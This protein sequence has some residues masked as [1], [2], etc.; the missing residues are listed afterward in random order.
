[1]LGFSQKETIN[2]EMI[3]L[4]EGETITINNTKIKF[5][6]VLEDSRCPK[7][8]SC[9]WEGRAKVLIKIEPENGQGYTKE[10][11]FGALRGNE[12][13][14]T[15]FIQEDEYF[16]EAISLKPYPEVDAKKD[17][18]VLWICEGS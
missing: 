13:A 5:L 12:K 18:Y 14:N 9:I 6:K 1:M 8:A 17:N 3:S 7:N 11:I 15:T 4:I 16:V 10:I 2:N